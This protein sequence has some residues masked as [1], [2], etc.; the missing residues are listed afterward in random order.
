MASRAALSIGGCLMPDY[1]VGKP[2]DTSHGAVLLAYIDTNALDFLCPHCHAGVG[3]FCRH[4]SGNERR[5]PCPR[6]I[7]AAAAGKATA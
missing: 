2:R 5:M 7:S 6:R 3:E 1:A 4:E